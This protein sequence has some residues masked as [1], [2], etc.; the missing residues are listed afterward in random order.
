MTF[1]MRSCGE[2]IQT[3][4]RQHG[5]TQLELAEKLNMSY[6]S[7][8]KIENGYHGISIETLLMMKELFHVSADYLLIGYTPISDF[9]RD[10]QQ[11][12]DTA[13]Q[14]RCRLGSILQ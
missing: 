14:L 13:A 11:I 8:A 4:R 1:D 3:L 2:R 12:I 9:D 10:L 7:I 6:S 5:W